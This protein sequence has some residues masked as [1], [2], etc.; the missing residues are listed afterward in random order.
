MP[1]KQIHLEFLLS[2]T[3]VDTDGLR[4]GRIEECHGVQSGDDFEIREF[5]LGPHALIERLT[6]WIPGSRLLK[7]LTRGEFGKTYKIPWDKIDISDPHH[8]RLLVAKSTLKPEPE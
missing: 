1:V 4:V 5:L 3:V 7:F 8:P 6:T 2:R